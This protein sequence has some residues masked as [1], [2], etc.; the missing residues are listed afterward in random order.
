[1][2]PEVSRAQVWNSPAITS[3]Y[4]ARSARDTSG[5]S[6]GATD[7]ARVEPNALRLASAFCAADDS[8]EEGHATRR[9]LKCIVAVRNHA[10]EEAREALGSVAVSWLGL[11]N[12]KPF[13]GRPQNNFRTFLLR[14]EGQEGAGAGG[15]GGAAGVPP[16]LFR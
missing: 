8:A 11:Y 14:P 5:A 3:A 15:G 10:S 6:G 4:S 2:M 12:A 1:M 13:L 7:P 9:R 16:G